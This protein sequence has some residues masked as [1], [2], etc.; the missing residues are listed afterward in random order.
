MNKKKLVVL[1]I[2]MVAILVLSSVLFIACNKQNEETPADDSSSSE[3]ETIEE[4][5]GLLIKNSD[6]K[7]VSTSTDSY[8]RT[9]TNWTGAKSYS[10]SSYPSSVIAGAISVESSLYSANASKWQDESGALRTLLLAGDRY[11]D[12]D[13][14]K[15]ALMI[16]MPTSDTDLG[17]SDATYGPT[18]YG[19]TSASFTIQAHKVYK[20]TVDVLTH[21]IAGDDSEG[22]NPGARI[23]LASSTYVDIDGIKT[24]DVWKTYEIYIE[25]SANGSNTLTLMLGLGKYTS[26]YQSGLT[27]GYAFFDNVNLVEVEA[28]DTKTAEEIF[29]EAVADELASNPLVKTATYKVPNGRFEY[30]TTTLSSSSAPSNWAYV[31]GNSSEEDAAPTSIGYNAIINLDDFADNFGQYSLNYYLKRDADTASESYKPADRLDNIKTNIVN[32]PTQ[33][34]GK[35]VFMLSQQL[36][37]AGG[38][39][40]SKQIT[41]EKNK[42]YELSIDVYTYDVHGA[43]VSLVLSGSDGK[44]ITIKGISTQVSSDVFIGATPIDVD[45]NSYVSGAAIDGATTGGWKTYS[46]YIVG[47]EYKDYNYYMTVWLGTDGTSSNNEVKYKSYSS[48]S[49][50]SELTTY[51]ANG[52]FANGWVFVDELNLKEIDAAPAASATIQNDAAS[53]TLDCAQGGMSDYVGIVVDLTTPNLFAGTGNDL[54]IGHSAAGASYAENGTTQHG[55][56]TGWTTAYEATA[57]APIIAGGVITDGLV[58]IDSEANFSATGGQ[59]DYPDKPYAIETETAYMIHSS[60]NAAYAINS[61]PF[62]IEANRFYRLSLWVKTVDVKSTS[63]VYVYLVDDEDSTISS[64]SKINT[65]DFSDYTNDWCEL[66]F[67][68]RGS[69]DEDEDMHIKFALGT[70]ER[71]EASTL[72]SGAAYISNL[73]LV[74]ISYSTFTSATTG[75]YVNSVDRTSSTTYTFT[76]ANFDEYDLDDDKLDPTLPLEGQNVL[77]QPKSWTINDSTLKPNSDESKLVAGVFA[78]AKDSAHPED[79]LKFDHSH[80]TD[81][82]FTNIAAAKFNSFYG[83]ESSAGYKSSANLKTINGPY[84]LALAS[85][86]NGT[87]YAVGY[88]SAKFSLSA[89]SSYAISVQVKGIGASKASVFLTGTTATSLGNDNA[90]LFLVENPSEDWTTYTYY[91]KVGFS[92]VSLNLNLWLG[93]D[94]TYVDGVSEDDAK[95][96]GAVFFDGV[97][98][99]SISDDEFDEQVEDAQ[100]KKISFLTDS[101]DSLSSTVESRASLTSPNNWSGS[102]GTDQSSSNTVSGVIYADSNFFEVKSVGGTDYVGIVGKNYTVDDVTLSDE[103]IEGKTDEEITELK[104]NKVVE[105]KQANWL[106]VSA[107]SANSGKNLLVINNT[108]ASAYTYTSSSITMSASSYYKVVVYARTYN[109]KAKLDDNGNVVDD[110]TIGANIELY[111]GTADKEDEPFIFKSQAQNDWTAYTFYVKTASSSVSSVSLR[112]SLGSVKTV[113]D[114][115]TGLTSGYAFFDDVTFEKIDEAA[116]NAATASDTVLL[117]EIEEPEEEDK[118]DDDDEEE[119]TDTEKKF[120]L[121]YLWWMI[122]TIILGALIIIVVIVYF[123]KK[124]SKPFKKAPSATS[125]EA[126]AK[127]RSRY[128]DSKE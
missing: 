85:T 39:K 105:L 24:D 73:S 44:D 16:Y 7:V 68:I 87:P 1:A 55:I 66:T 18:A 92:S 124:F 101:F 25:G 6:F 114:V 74:A 77:A 100:N 113:D 95:S 127:K 83:D 71:F 60:K 26:T 120:N 32:F 30:G 67:L 90:S 97:V 64:F 28:T 70:G 50:S 49:S 69:F 22:S 63:G 34:V 76:N 17:D 29:A 47:N 46:F 27:T 103:E 125:K 53:W 82:V 42:I 37:T 94:T 102:A 112:L 58:Q 84:V 86:D 4:T 3:T 99:K 65:A 128:D 75:S 48:T 116:Y 23:Y 93:Y 31:T 20:L 109:L 123:V 89:N 62:T 111:L 119:N 59:G 110:D 45:D 126:I 56:P 108:S 8:P 14:I 81:E 51:R 104:N 9:I 96:L 79:V 36:M 5:E 40:S 80:Q 43:G 72:T 35:N 91:V 54:A 88:A 2:L 33:R 57:S 38:I 13:K 19:Y 106:P 117:R 21:N 11:G 118:D 121:E 61:A 10:S 15:H 12:D 98:Q 115:T 78:L 107:L 52:T 122:P 41:I